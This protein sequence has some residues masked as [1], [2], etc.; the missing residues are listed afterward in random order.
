MMR[1]WIKVLASLVVLLGLWAPQA[2]GQKQVEKLGRGA[3]AIREGSGYWINWRLLGDEPYATAFNIYRDGTKLNE[4]VIADVTAY[5]DADAPLGSQYIVK[6]VIDGVEQAEVY[7]ARVIDNREGTGGWFDIPLKRP[8]QGPEGGY[9]HSNDASVGDLLGNGEYEI[10]LKWDPDNAKDNSQGGITDNVFLDGYTMDGKHLW[11]IDLGPNIR[12]GAHYTQ[13][14][15]YDF[16]GNG[17]AEIMVKTAPGTK[18]GTG[19]FLSK[20]PAAS[21]NHNQIYRNDWGYILSGPEYIT[22]FDGAT[23]EEL[24]TADYWPL[25]GAVSSWG[26]NYGNRVDRFN[27]A[28]AYVDGERPTGV[29]Q[30][31]YYTRMTFAAWDWRDGELTRKW[32]FDSNTNGNGAYYSQGNHSLHVIDANGDG[33]HD[34]VTG[35]A[36]ISGDGTGMH[37]TGFGHADAT[38]ITYMKKGDTRPMIWMP[39][40]SGSNGVLLRYADNGEVVFHYPAP[41]DIGR[42]AAAELDPQRPG[43]HFWASGHGLFDIKGVRV[44]NN[45]SSTNFLIWWDGN[46]SRELLNSNRID[47]W[48]I[49]SSSGTNLLTGNGTYSNN[50]S[51]STPTLSADLFGDWREEVIFRRSDSEALRVYTTAIQTDHKL[52]T[53]MHDP[54]YRAAISWQN[55]SYNQPPHPGFYLATDMDF[56]MAAPHVDVLESIAR[57]SGQTVSDLMLFDFN[58]GPLWEVMPSLNGETSIFGDLNFYFSEGP[59]YLNQKEWIRTSMESRKLPADLTLATFVAQKDADVYVLHQKAISEL[60]SWLND[61]ELV[62]EPVSVASAAGSKV[63]MNLFR[64]QVLAGENV[65]LGGNTITGASGNL[66]YFV[67]ADAGVINSINT[68]G[69]IAGYELIVSPNP[70]NGNALVHI[71]LAVDQQVTLSLYDLNGRLMKV[72]DQGW[73]SSGAHSVNLNATSFAPGVYILQMV[74]EAGVKQQKVLIQ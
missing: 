66:M 45:P 24:A 15:V 48:N 8:A 14:L 30:R 4:E 23:G 5:M 35:A 2:L 40:E 7:P 57:G 59:E 6:A 29:F 46:L 65:V 28:V 63:P 37:T 69:S 16:D 12:A 22:V 53:L 25:R 55:S 64:K 74:T 33:L 3:I 10:V 34:L 21:A 26:D 19:N 20:G 61:W 73:R 32:T 51:K 68:Q 1:S 41:G 11:R 42:A 58:G 27:A 44:G 56:P 13:F 52:Y 43:F 49:G 17:K 18:D 9:Y 70:L 47:R 67:V 62:D 72:I 39:H 38:H 54:V 50:G 31:G 71:R 60:P 36:V